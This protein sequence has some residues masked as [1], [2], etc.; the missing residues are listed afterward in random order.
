M[1]LLASPNANNHLISQKKTRKK[2]SKKQISYQYHI[3]II[4]WFFILIFKLVCIF[5][6]CCSDDISPHFLAW[7]KNVQLSSNMTKEREQATEKKCSRFVFLL[8][9]VVYSCWCCCCCTQTTNSCN[10]VA[11]MFFDSFVTPAKKVQWE[12]NISP[13]CRD[14]QKCDSCLF[15][16]L[17]FFLVH[18]TNN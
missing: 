9:F 4:V 11:N 7:P 16:C 5:L 13:Q 6:V 10:Y 18:F 14:Q 15:N 1:G 2:E 12:N 8:L 3:E 17:A